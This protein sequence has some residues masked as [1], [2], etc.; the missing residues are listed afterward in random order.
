MKIRLANAVRSLGFLLGGLMA[1]VA[2]AALFVWVSFDAE[3]AADALSTHFRDQYERTLMLTEKP[4]L[5]LWPRP[6]LSLHKVSLGESGL[7]RNFAT[8]TDLRIELAIMPLLHHEFELRGVSASGVTLHLRQ[9]P[10]GEWNAAD[11]LAADADEAPQGW[12]G[13]LQKL[14]L[15][16]AQVSIEALG[17]KTPIELDE[18]NATLTLPPD[19]QPGS[20]KWQASL[21]DAGNESELGIKGQASVVLE[22]AL[23]AGRLTGIGLELDGDSHG[24]RGATVRMSVDTLSWHKLGSTGELAGLKLRIRGA[25]GA[26]AVDFSTQWPA[27][28]WQGRA[29]RGKDLV[30]RLDT[31]TV[32]SHDEIRLGIPSLLADAPNGGRS[33]DASLDW[34]HEA[35]KDST[36]SLK[37]ALEAR[38]DLL[39]RAI[40]ATRLKGE[41]QLRHPALREAPA[42]LG[43]DGKLR[44]QTGS[45]EFDTTLAHGE[46]RLGLKASLHDS[47]PPGGRF[48]LGTEGFDL[49]RLLTSAA[50]QP[51]PALPWL[52]P[53]GSSLDGQLSLAGLRFAGLQIASL[54]GPVTIRDGNIGSERLNARLHDGQLSTSLQAEAASRR[55]TLQGDFSALT[56]ERIADEMR[57]P[58]PLSG[59]ASGSFRLAGLL[60]P[61]QP[62]APT[63][64]GAL[65]WNLEQ[66]GLRGLDLAEGLRELLPAISAA[67]MSARSPG[68]DER[69]EL[70][71]AASRFVFANG[72]ASAEQI[73]SKGSWVRLN[74]SGLA[75][76]ASGGVD[77]RLQAAVQAAPP[78]ELLALRGKT[79]PLHVKGPA[80]QPDLRYEPPPAGKGRP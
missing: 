78:K 51:L 1:I 8:A 15:K 29:I 69:T 79:V 53:A 46:D 23:R 45:L 36:A 30:A 3:A 17:H 71:T 63:L 24:L 20:L 16:D 66:A 75:D 60:K 38:V 68:Q 2:A 33:P 72:Q 48:T 4:R 7:N 61:G 47:W 76:L 42:R 80:L 6:A 11:L 57:L 58:V 44:W 21:H 62:V 25:Q 19:G 5:S 12:S 49:D 54:Q 64:E 18:L 43:L 35:G 27:L 32:S 10:T 9:L 34:Q 52:A 74:G 37:L 55:F 14:V 50:G 41:L 59:K 40:D 77:F 70:G 28:A 56:V 26:N 31:R 67:R 65:R 13:R 22:H 73:E 39:A